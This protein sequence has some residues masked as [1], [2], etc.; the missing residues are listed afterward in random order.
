MF[1][2]R[3]LFR[4]REAQFTECPDHFDHPDVKRMTLRELADLPPPQMCETQRRTK[5]NC[6]RAKREP[7]EVRGGNEAITN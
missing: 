6:G 1:N 2:F 5:A 3:R 4:T 7:E